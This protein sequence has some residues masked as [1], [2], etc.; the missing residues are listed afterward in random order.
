MT[1]NHDYVWL[2]CIIDT[3]TPAQIFP[4]VHENQL[5]WN[6]PMSGVLLWGLG[7]CPSGRRK[8]SLLDKHSMDPLRDGRVR[9]FPTNT[10]LSG[11]GMDVSGSSLPTLTYLCRAE[12]SRGFWNRELDVNAEVFDW[13]G[14]LANV[15]GP[16]QKDGESQ[17]NRYMLTCRCYALYNWCIY[18]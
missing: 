10:Y 12:R 17:R 5:R 15:S 13:P 8:E 11:E 3:I 9:L 16:S 18:I 1:T 14:F 6:R 2:L 4:G 7:T